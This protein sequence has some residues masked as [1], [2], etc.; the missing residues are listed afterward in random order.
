MYEIT[1]TKTK[2]VRRVQRGE[3]VKVG[4]VKAEKDGDE[5]FFVGGIKDAYEYG[6]DRITESLEE[7]E[8]FKQK[9]DDLDLVAVINAVNA[10]KLNA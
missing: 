10:K 3:F 9:V 4:Q 6:P 2:T 5:R 7:D 8:I 1:I